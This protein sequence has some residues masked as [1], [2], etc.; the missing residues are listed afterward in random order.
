MKKAKYQ[1][2]AYIFISVA[3]FYTVILQSKL[4]E[5]DLR[6]EPNLAPSY[7][8]VGAL[9]SETQPPPRAV[10]ND[11]VLAKPSSLGRL[12]PASHSDGGALQIPLQHDVPFVF[13]SSAYSRQNNQRNRSLPVLFLYTQG[14]YIFNDKTGYIVSL[15]ITSCLVGTHSYP[16]LYESN[17][18]YACNISREIRDGEPLSL[19]LSPTIYDGDTEG[20]WYS[21]LLQHVKLMSTT[22]NGSYILPSD[23]FWERQIDPPVRRNE[24]RYEVCLMTQEKV[25]AEFLPEWVEYHRKLGVDHVYIYDNNA[26]YNISEMFE[27]DSDVEVVHWPWL[28]SQIQAQNHFIVNGRRRC[29][30]AILIDVDEFVMMHVMDPAD[31][32]NALKLYLRGMREEND[33]SSVRLPTIVLGSSGHKVRPRMP[34]AE[35]YWHSALPQDNRTK[36]IVWLGHALP[37]SFVHFIKFPKGYHLLYNAKG[38]RTQRGIEAQVVHMKFRSCY[39][40]VQKGYGGRNSM[41]VKLWNIT[42]VWDPSETHLK[43][44]NGESFT[45][46]RTSWRRVVARTAKEAKLVRYNERV[47]RKKRGKNV[48]SAQENHFISSIIEGE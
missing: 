13:T 44:L 18:L 30:W 31:E 46:F 15:N 37:D 3:L 1:F 7:R 26:T 39:D 38:C 6:R 22:D 21:S 33:Y 12:L 23:A 5:Q 42:S 35:A 8:N 17:G 36:P 9:N 16:L 4:I 34:M 14:T 43:R 40:Y 28:R 25:F 45:D 11:H 41:S 27:H 24:G 29:E 48:S 10:G 2:A 32:E 47:R 19:L 20:D